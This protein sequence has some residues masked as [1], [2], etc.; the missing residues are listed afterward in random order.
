MKAHL[1]C[2]KNNWAG[3]IVGLLGAFL[4]QGC[5]TP[6]VKV[7]NQ[8]IVGECSDDDNFDGVGA[9]SNQLIMGRQQIFGTRILTISFKPLKI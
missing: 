7:D 8:T 4:I 1:P 3:F 2:L 5:T 6:L 9:C